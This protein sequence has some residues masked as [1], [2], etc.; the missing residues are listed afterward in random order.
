MRHDLIVRL[1]IGEDLV[2]LGDLLELLGGVVLV[3]GVLVRVPLERQASI[4]VRSREKM[5]NECTFSV[6]N[7][8]ISCKEDYKLK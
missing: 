8:I 2:S 7:S 3:L 6:I 1:T 4:S 5:Q